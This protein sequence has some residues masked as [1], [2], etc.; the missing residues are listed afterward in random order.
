MIIYPICSSS[1][2]NCTYV[3]SEDTALLIDAGFGIR[4]LYKYLSNANFSNKNIKAIFITHEHTDHISGLCSIVKNLCIPIFASKGTINYL[5]NKNKICPEAELH[6]I[7]PHKPIYIGDFEVSAFLTPHDSAESLGFCIQNNNKKFS[8]CTDIGHITSIIKE[9]LIDSDFILLE[10]NYDCNLLQ[11]SPY[12]HYLKK[13]IM[14]N[15]GHLSNDDTAKFIEYLIYNGVNR[16]LLGHLSQ[17]NNTPDLALQTVISY[18][19]E[20][21]LKIN[22]DYL[23]NVAPVRN[24]NYILYEV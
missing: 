22:K 18:L 4:N 12:P 5:L 14:S 2:G 13:R 11:I 7:T 3:C 9:K 6:E 17:M 16:F 8:I 15:L 19:I 24:N 21:K 1:K 10:S 20:Q 23:L